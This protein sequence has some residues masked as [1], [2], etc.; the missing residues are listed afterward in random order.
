MPRDNEKGLL[1]GLFRY[2]TKPIKVDEFMNT[3][4]AGLQFA[5][6]SGSRAK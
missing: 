6:K 1:A 3:V 5:E 2:L 4:D